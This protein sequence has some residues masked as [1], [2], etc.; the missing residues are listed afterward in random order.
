MRIRIKKPSRFA[1][2]LKELFDVYC[3]RY[4]SQG[5]KNK[6]SVLYGPVFYF[7]KEGKQTPDFW[8]NDRSFP[9]NTQFKKIMSILE[10]V[11][12][13]DYSNL[14]DSMRIE[15][16]ERSQKIYHDFMVLLVTSTI[17]GIKWRHDIV[18]IVLMLG[19]TE[20]NSISEYL[21]FN[22][23]NDSFLKGITSLGFRKISVPLAKDLL[24]I[25]T[26]VQLVIADESKDIHFPGFVE[27][28][29]HANHDE[30]A[31]NIFE[32]GSRYNHWSEQNPDKVFMLSESLRPIVKKHK[33][34]MLAEIKE[35]IKNVGPS[36][37]NLN[38][39]N[40]TPE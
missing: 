30:N 24:Q 12:S 28:L 16:L 1:V 4:Y 13:E 38:N 36:I 32:V 11:R 26:L 19:R 10:S 3:D 31:Y 37:F 25:T 6:H 40:K 27:W 20:A 17:D 9:D 18:K 33:D 29:D 8:I 7:S 2:L 34:A 14:V 39:T 5:K 22:S 15:K 35:H 21:F 23:G